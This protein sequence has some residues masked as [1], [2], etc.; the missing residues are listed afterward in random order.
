MENSNCSQCFSTG[1][2][3]QERGFAHV[4]ESYEVPSSE[5]PSLTSPHA[6][7]PVID[8][9]GLRAGPSE[10]STVVESVRQ[11]CYRFGFFHVNLVVTFS[12]LE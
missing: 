4:P 5:R 6:E 12:F 10:R 9:A 7:V 11:A 3:A 1:Q 8:L 2:S